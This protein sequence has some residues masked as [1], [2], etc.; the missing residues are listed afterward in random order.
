MTGMQRIGWLRRLSRSAAGTA[1]GLAGLL[2]LSPPAT[3]QPLALRGAA[4]RLDEGAGASLVP[5]SPTRVRRVFEEV[6]LVREAASWRAEVVEIF[7]GGPVPETVHLGLPE[8]E[9]PDDSLST[10][11]VS[12]LRF[13]LDG[14]EIAPDSASAPP[15]DVG[16]PAGIRKFHSWRIPFRADEVRAVR[17][18]YR[19]RPTRTDT[20]E[21]MLFFYLNPGT[22]WAGPSGR[23]NLRADLGAAESA[24]LVAEWLRPTEYF[25][26][27]HTV[28]WRLDLEEPD[29]DLVLALRPAE[30]WLATTPNREDGLLSLEPEARSTRL[31]GATARELSFWRAHLWAR[32]GA[33]PTDAAERRALTEE[34]WFRAASQPTP[35]EEWSGPERA[36][37]AEIEDRLDQWGRRRLP[38]PEEARSQ[39]QPTGEDLSG[40]P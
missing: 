39:T 19:V 24:D 6:H 12:D 26:S 38:S 9:A 15:E 22:P 14:Y 8:F 16:A 7:V 33:V 5:L 29:Q 10:P 25:V 20:G 30:D 28:H 3:A 1:L 37:L 4:P 18:T 27:E 40:A 34:A 36:L 23:I 11:T 35:V 21:E 32:R 2:L 13:T 31:A 17:L